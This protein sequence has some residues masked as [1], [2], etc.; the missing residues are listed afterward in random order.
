MSCLVSEPRV[1][2]ARMTTLARRSYPGSKLLFCCAALVHAFVVGAHANH[3]ACFKQKLG[4][5]ESGEDGNAG[6]LYL[7]AQPLHELVD[8]DD[9]VA[10]IAHRRRSDGK[11]EFAGAGQEVNRLL[12]DRG[13]ERRFLFE[14]GKQLAHGTRIKQRAGEAMRANVARL[15]QQVDVLFGKRGF[16]V[17]ALCSSISCESRKAH[18]MP[19][20]PPPTMT[21]SAS[22]TGRSTS[23]S[24]LRNTIMRDLS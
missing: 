14:A 5:G 13:I 17:L 3:A 24:G 7:A 9:I 1:P 4:A 8:G 15:L 22:M 16:R 2:S 18:A 23:G 10:V 21:T 6:F 19:A 12:H 20:G 11:L